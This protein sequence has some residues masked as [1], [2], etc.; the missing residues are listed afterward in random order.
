MN[1]INDYESYDNTWKFIVQPQ[2]F[3]YE[4]LLNVNIFKPHVKQHFLKCAFG[5][6][7]GCTCHLVTPLSPPTSPINSLFFEL[8]MT[9]Q[10]PSMPMESNDLPM[11]TQEYH[12]DS[13]VESLPSPPDLITTSS[14]GSMSPALRTK[15]KFKCDLCES[16][17]SRNHDLKRHSRIHTGVKPYQCLE[18]G[19]SFTR[20]DALN[21]HT[22]VKGCKGL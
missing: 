13:P 15:K 4:S 2:D 20:Q 11:L 7:F 3:E 14:Q 1:S 16:S 9:F 18:C 21:R 22:T 10:E 6:S 19:K 5:C 12:Y 8:D 17:F